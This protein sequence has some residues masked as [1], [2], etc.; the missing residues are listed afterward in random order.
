M[1]NDQ[2]SAGSPIAIPFPAQSELEHRAAAAEVPVH[3]VRRISSVLSGFMTLLCGGCCGGMVAAIC[4][5][6]SQKDGGWEDA[7]GFIVLGPILGLGTV[8]FGF[9]TWRWARSLPPTEII[10]IAQ[11]EMAQSEMAQSEKH[12]LAR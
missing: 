5:A 1:Q 2:R 3:H 9:L 4:V 6:I 11:S 10:A 12:E 7:L 8:A